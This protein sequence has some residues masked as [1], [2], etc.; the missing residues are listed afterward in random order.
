MEQEEQHKNK[1]F[2]IGFIVVGVLSST[3]LSLTIWIQTTW[4]K[5]FVRIKAV[6]YLQEKVGGKI[7][8]GTLNY[9]IPNW[10]QVNNV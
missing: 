9:S 7:I 1:W 6:N 8:L 4:G 10:V 2:R 5:N 3:I